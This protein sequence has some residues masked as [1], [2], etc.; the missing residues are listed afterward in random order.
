MAVTEHLETQENQ[1]K[2]EEPADQDTRDH[3][4]SATLRRARELRFTGSPPTPKT[5]NT[6]K[7]QIPFQEC[8]GRR[9]GTEEVSVDIKAAFS[10]LNKRPEWK[11]QD[12]I[13][14]TQEHPQ[15]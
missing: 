15:A 14:V 10:E 13:S 1:E 9:N 12:S 7:E 6:Q 2:P 3:L 4:E 11:V 5:I 8:F